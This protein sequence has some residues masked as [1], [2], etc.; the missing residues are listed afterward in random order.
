MIEVAF[1]EY[2]GEHSDEYMTPSVSVVDIQV[3]GVIC[4]SNETLDDYLGDW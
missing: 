2:R 1:N 3:E 4:G